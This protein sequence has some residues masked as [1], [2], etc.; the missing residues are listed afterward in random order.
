[1]YAREGTLSSARAP[2]DADR[3]IV[4]GAIDLLGSDR[5]GWAGR[6]DEES[7]ADRTVSR[8]GLG[9]RSTPI[10][11]GLRLAHAL[12]RPVHQKQKATR[13]SAK[14]RKIVVSQAWNAQYRLAGWSVATLW[15]PRRS[16]HCS[17]KESG[18]LGEPWHAAASVLV[19]KPAGSPVAT[20]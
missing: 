13:A 17:K 9:W 19:L 14:A 2:C 5:S 8:A 18:R 12:R 16:A 1:M 15:S 20:T 4:T 10:R 7:R 6:A 11:E 3:L